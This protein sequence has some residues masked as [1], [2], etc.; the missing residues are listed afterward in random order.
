M[1]GNLLDVQHLREELHHPLAGLGVDAAAHPPEIPHRGDVILAGH[2]PLEG[3]GEQRGFPGDAAALE[4]LL[5]DGVGH[6]LGGAG[7][8]RG[9]DQ[10]HAVGLDL[11]ADDLEAL[12]ERLDVGAALAHVAEGVLVVVALHVHDHHVG[13]LEHVVGVGGDQGL[14]VLDAALDHPRHLGVVGIH[15]RHPLVEVGD[16]PERARRGPLHADDELAGG[17]GLAVDRIGHHTGHDRADEAHPH[18]DHDLAA[19]FAFRGHDALKP[20]VLACV[21]LLPRQGEGLPLGAD[22]NKCRR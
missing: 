22:G 1:S 15:R 7:R 4:L 21:V 17:S 18:D 11:L 10:H 16:L 19:F 9:F 12:L 3:V 13:K 8:H 14:F 20:L 6:V 2:D 5:D